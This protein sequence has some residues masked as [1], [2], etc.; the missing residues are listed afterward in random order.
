MKNQN[1]KNNWNFNKLKFLLNIK[2]FKIKK[3]S[4]MH[5]KITTS[6]ITLLGIIFFY[7]S[8]FATIRTV[9]V[10]NFSFSPQNVNANIGDT[11]QWVWID[12]NHTTTSTSVPMGAA[13]WDALISSGSP[14]FEYPITISGLYNYQ[15][16]P[17]GSM[18]MTGTIIVSIES[19]KEISG[20]A[21][22]YKLNQNYPNP[23]NPVTKIN[24]SIAKA[25]SVTLKIYD[26]SGKEVSTLVNAN[27]N[28][29][30]YEVTFDG[31]N[32]SSGIY[33]YRIS[34]GDF[35]EVRKMA[36]IK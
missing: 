31:S 29:G 21:D 22:N 13:T 12:G 10:Q 5:N 32:F 34:T 33:Y 7:S 17:H 19:V 26:I 16:T 24:F 27:L 28:K 23:F 35:S 15:C 18:G 6:I 11:I 20:T 30:S 36:L 14:T 3:I 9:N 2:F 4:L 1:K 8:S 25:G